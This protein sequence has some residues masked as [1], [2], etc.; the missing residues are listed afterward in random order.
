MHPDAEF[1]AA[2]IREERPS[3][4]MRGFDQDVANRTRAV[5]AAVALGM[6]DRNLKVALPTTPTG[7]RY[8]LSEEVE[9]LKK[10]TTIQEIETVADEGDFV[11]LSGRDMRLKYGFAS[12]LAANHR[13]LANELSL[14]TGNLE[15]NPSLG[16]E[17]QAVQVQLAG[18]IN[19]SNIDRTLRAIEAKRRLGS[20][21][22]ICLLLDSPGGSPADS[23]ELANYLSLLDSS[24][25]RTV[26][27]VAN[28]ALGDA[29]VI[30]L[31]CDHLVMERAAILGGPGTYQPNADDIG[32]LKVA[33]QRICA[34]KSR[35]WSLPLGLLDADLVVNRYSVAGTDVV[36]YFCEE[37]WQAQADPD[38]WVRGELVRR[39]AGRCRRWARWRRSWTWRSMSSRILPT[40]KSPTA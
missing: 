3:A 16:G 21:N 9:P 32:D 10:E 30:A 39:K 5:P 31:A 2:G 22:L 1:G 23:V 12:R 7:V 29:A 11:R 24:Q 27:Y 37:E 15:P 40:S 6:L 19:K 17:W 26:A 28:Q 14:A 35:S 34:D 8:V 20:V 4:M 18:P 38:Q 25:I 13:E 36:D 33:L